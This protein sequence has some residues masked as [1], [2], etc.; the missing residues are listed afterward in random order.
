MADQAKLDDVFPGGPPCAAH[1]AQTQ[2]LDI[3]VE[4]VEDCL[5]DVRGSV[6]DMK[7]SVREIELH[8]AKQNGTLPRIESTV[9]EIS[10][11]LRDDEK[12]GAVSQAENRTR[13]RVTW[14]L[15]GGIF[16]AILGIAMKFFLT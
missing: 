9:A 8:I 15:I 6:H 12:A 14:T 4:H 11:R 10:K 7:A 5:N 3:R 2:K 1:Y 13:D 16:V